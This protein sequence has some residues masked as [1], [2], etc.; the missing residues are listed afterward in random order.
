VVVVVVVVVV[1]A[2]ALLL[3][4]LL[5]LLSPAPVRHWQWRTQHQSRAMLSAPRLLLPH[6]VQPD[7]Q[8]GSV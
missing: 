2:S 8:R 6:S 4:L 5:L 7:F 3:L 1:A